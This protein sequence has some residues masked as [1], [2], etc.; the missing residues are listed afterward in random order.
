MVVYLPVMA[1]FQTVRLSRGRHRSPGHGVCVAELTSMIAGE[2]FSDHPSCACPAVTAFLRAYNDRIDDER[3]QDLYALA[4]ELVGSRR[5]EAVT[6][7]RADQLLALAWRHRERIGPLT[8][9]PRLNY[10]HRLDRCEAAGDH[11]GRCALRT[12]GVH[13]EVLREIR[14]LIARPAPL[15][16]AEIT[17][18]AQRVSQPWATAPA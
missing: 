11:L 5:A 7:Q 16:T 14:A 15:A 6:Q 8:R 1:S 4:S 3:R 9:F 12:P 2:R 10:A 13:D 17:A 18:A